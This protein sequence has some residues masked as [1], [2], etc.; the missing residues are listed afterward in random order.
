MHKS[1]LAVVVGLVL[2]VSPVTGFDPENGFKDLGKQGD[3]L[4][5]QAK[6]LQTKAAAAA[7]AKEPFDP[8]NGARGTDRARAKVA[9]ADRCCAANIR[10]L[11]STIGALRTGT[12]Q[13]QAHFRQQKQARWVTGFGDVQTTVASATAALDTFATATDATSALA[14][15]G[16]LS[17]AANGVKTKIAGLDSCCIAK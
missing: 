12:E 15:V 5:Q 2:A 9:W 1:S 4:I 14:A 17:T 3:I 10:E 11:R 7:Q 8:E 13:L 6:T 16:T